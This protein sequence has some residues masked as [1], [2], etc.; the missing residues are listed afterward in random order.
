MASYFV[1]NL[2]GQLAMAVALQ[3]QEQGARGAGPG[4]HRGGRRGGAHTVERWQMEMRD[5]MHNL[6]MR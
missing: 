1:F 5:P 4:A 3:L 2:F 6:R